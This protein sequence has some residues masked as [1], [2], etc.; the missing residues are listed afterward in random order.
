MSESKR[1]R[2][3]RYRLPHRWILLPA[4]LATAATGLLGWRWLATLPCRQIVIEGAHHAE[5]AALLDLARVD[6]GMV[7]FDLDPALVADRLVRHPWVAHAEVTRLPTGTLAIDVEERRPVA[8][9]V[10]ADGAPSHYLDATGAQMPLVPGAA[11]DV[12][13]VRGLR[14]PYHPVQPV[15]EEAV[16]AFLAALAAVPPEVEALVSEVEVR[17]GELW[18]YTTPGPAREAVP[19]RLGRMGFSDKLTRLHAF[20][21]QAV[22]P[23]PEKHFRLIDLRFD[24]QIVTEEQ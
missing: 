22:L 15:Q 9:V 16:R 5:R 19:V 6:T 1:S 8:L 14:Q 18:A 23:R 3:G 4:L 2:R 20:W 7:L 24:S 10:G 13:L 11:Y 21:H 12:P 17:G